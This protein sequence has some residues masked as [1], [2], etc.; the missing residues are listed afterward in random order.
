MEHDGSSIIQV[1]CSHLWRDLN[2]WPEMLGFIRQETVPVY[3][4]HPFLPDSLLS[5]VF[6]PFCSLPNLFP[7]SRLYAPARSCLKNPRD[8]GAWWAA[9]YGIAQ[10][11]TRLKW[12]SSSSS[13]ILT[14]KT[15][16]W[17]SR[18]PLFTF[19]DSFYFENC[20]S[21]NLFQKDC[22]SHGHQ[23]CHCRVSRVFHILRQSD[24]SRAE[25]K[26]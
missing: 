10:S 7:A 26:D 18:Q 13:S 9:I 5:A 24:C 2:A 15:Q 4:S 12:L 20:P 23:L 17:D 21:P 16:E 11:Q 25:Y 3:L 19:P 8:R 14:Y 22:Q 1:D 6:T